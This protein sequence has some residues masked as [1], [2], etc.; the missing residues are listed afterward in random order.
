[1]EAFHVLFW[2]Q[3]YFV[4]VQDE[5]DELCN[6]SKELQI[7]SRPHSQFHSNP[8]IEYN[9]A[10]LENC[11]DSEKSYEYLKKRQVMFN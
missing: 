6:P 1:M 2:S 11:I 8:D 4:Q 5:P 3:S 9:S 10:E 7:Q